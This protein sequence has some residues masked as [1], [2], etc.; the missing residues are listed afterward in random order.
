VSS[1]LGRAV[2]TFVPP[3]ALLAAFGAGLL[4][5]GVPPAYVVAAVGLL[6]VGVLVGVG[7]TPHSRLEVGPRGRVIEGEMVRH[8]PCDD[9]GADAVWGRQREYRRE[10]VL[11]GTPVW[12]LET[13]ENV[14]CRA[15]ADDP[16]LTAVGTE[17]SVVPN[18]DI[19]T[20]R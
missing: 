19:E 14:Y 4:A 8:V 18:R 9:C 16:A 20:E 13:G 2:Q 15:C 3:A 11:F 10:L 7:H 17:S 1:T 5:V 6:L 12:T